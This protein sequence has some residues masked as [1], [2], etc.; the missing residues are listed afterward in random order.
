MR[1]KRPSTC[2]M[3]SCFVCK[4]MCN[5]GAVGFTFTCNDHCNS[6]HERC[7]LFEDAST[8]TITRDRRLG[9]CPDATSPPSVPPT[10]QPTNN[11]TPAPTVSPT[12]DPSA[13]PTSSTTKPESTV[14]PTPKPTPPRLLP[15]CMSL[16]QMRLQGEQ[17]L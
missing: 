1:T 15:P 13:L 3:T 12:P 6:Y 14:S 10:N 2:F 9:C 4:F 8:C 16:K 11:P 5:G 17:G 7:L